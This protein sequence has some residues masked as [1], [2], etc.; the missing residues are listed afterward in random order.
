MTNQLIGLNTCSCKKTKHPFSKIVITGGPGAGKSAISEL[1]KLQLCSHVAVLP[2]AAT[3]LFRGGFWR[4]NTINGRESAQRTI[5]HIQRE[6]E[7]FVNREKKYSVAIC[8]RGTLDGL[9]YWPNSPSSFFK[10]LNTSR[11][12]EFLN[13]SAVIHLRTPSKNR[14][15]NLQNSMRLESAKEARLMD[16]KIEKAWKGH[17]RRF[18]IDSTESFDE[19]IE[20][21]LVILRQE[22]PSCCS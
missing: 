19:K 17:P 1:A 11:S 13:Y 9:A 4:E 12:Q 2:E 15:Y 8:D 14:G 3:L 5:F 21:T 22:I 6:M 10:N 16:K 18:F 7:R 20:N